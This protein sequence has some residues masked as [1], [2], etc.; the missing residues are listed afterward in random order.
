MSPPRVST[1]LLSETR[2]NTSTSS[3]RNGA[4]GPLVILSGPTPT[5]HTQTC[6]ALPL[7]S[8]ARQN[9]NVNVTLLGTGA[10]D[11]WPNPWCDC[12]S[13]Q[14]GSQRGVLRA[15]SAALVDRRLLLDCG[16]EAPRQALRAGTDLRGTRVVAIGHA[17]HDHLDPAFLL[18]RSWLSEVGR[19]TVVGPAPVIAQCRTWLNP[20]QTDVELRQVSAGDQI[21][22]DGFT[23]SALAA[24]HDAFGEALL[25]QVSD[26]RSKL[27]WATDTGPLPESTFTALADAEL[28]LLLL[29]ETFGNYLD[30]GQR[31]LDLPGFRSTLE[32]LRGQ[33]TV[34]PQTD[35]IAIHLSHL[36]PPLA[37]LTEALADCGARC[38]PDGT[39][40]RC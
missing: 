12:L 10:A 17:H 21:S 40:L 16:P 15:P 1:N 6:P 39:T 28:D 7:G 27:L 5:C 37:E 20:N 4:V 11:G 31:H 30:H 18:Y 38:V 26:G 35:V 25:Y 13:C 23:I 36:N 32:R 29:E 33:R 19:L 2:T 24:N 14:D 9:S 3:P 34:T 8:P 22:L